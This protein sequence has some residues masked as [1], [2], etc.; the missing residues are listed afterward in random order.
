MTG[1]NVLRSMERGEPWTAGLREFQAFLPL[2]AR[3]PFF[4]YSALVTVRIARAKGPRSA[5]WEAATMNS[6][7]NDASASRPPA[8]RRWRYPVLLGL[9]VGAGFGLWNL[10]ESWV[11]PQADDTPGALLMFYGPM[12]TIWGL[13]GF[14]AARRTGRV[15][16]AVKVG[17]TVAFVTFVVY[18]LA[19]FL[20]VN[21]LLDTL[22]QR[23]D[24]RHMVTV[25]FP[26]SG[27]RSLR[28]YVNYEGVT[29]APFK[30]LVA[31]TIGAVTGLI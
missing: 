8:R 27:F 6:P 3:R 22:S 12:F 17:A 20:R 30:L 18:T 1:G 25:R 4:S 11:D 14:G 9:I 21:L 31:S 19:V 26:A 15:S 13:V 16:D 24:W 5:R 28:A 7:Q 29:G 2:D 10:I 23:S